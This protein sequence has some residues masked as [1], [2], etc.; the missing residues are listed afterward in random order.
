MADEGLNLLEIKRDHNDF[1]IIVL[2][3]TPDHMQGFLSVTILPGG[4]VSEEDLRTFLMEAEVHYG[5]MDDALAGIVE[6]CDNGENVENVLFAE[7][8]EKVDGVDGFI[9][10]I[11]KPSGMQDIALEKTSD[12]AVINYKEIMAVENVKQGDLVAEYEPPV[13]GQGGEDIFGRINPPKDSKDFIFNVGDTVTLSKDTNQIFANTYGHVSFEKKTINVSQVYYVRGNVDLRVGNIR[14]VGRVDISGDILDDFEVTAE[15]G[16]SV[17][18]TAES[19]LMQSESDIV[20][21]GGVTGKDKGKI[22]AKG[23]IYA[24]FLNEVEVISGEDVI[25]DNEIVNS[26]VFALGRVIMPR[27]S[28]VNSEVVALKGIIANDVGSDLGVKTMVTA[29]LD[30]HFAAKLYEI[31]HD[32][33]KLVERQRIMMNKFGPMVEAALKAPSVTIDKKEEIDEMW[34]EIRVLQRRIVKLEKESGDIS[35]TF[36]EEALPII[37]VNGKTYPGVILIADKYEAQVKSEM[38]GPLSVEP[39]KINKKI[40]IVSQKENSPVLER[41]IRPPEWENSGKESNA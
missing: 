3:A 41:P 36:S 23:N 25:V 10:W 38:A 11:K 15:K 29:G 34:Q 4:G 30:Y 31:N 28:I 40:K 24:R 26:K 33:M 1:R 35:Q 12:D 5:I 18:G 14:F 19:C 21:K 20:I 37:D 2:S 17:G 6:K 9:R 27:G 8:R 39:D 32:L 16:I 7:G 22:E 13:E